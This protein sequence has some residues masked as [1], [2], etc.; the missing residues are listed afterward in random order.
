[1]SASARVERFVASGE[2]AGRRLDVFLARQLPALSRSRLQALIRAGA[3]TAAGR[4]G[5][6]ST[7]VVE[8]EIVE[9]AIPAP[10]PSHLEPEALPLT[11]VYEDADLAVIDK[12][13]G[14]V[15]HPGAGHR[16]GTLVHALLH[17]LE[18]L[19]GIGGTERPGIVHRLDRG[20]SGLIVIAKHDA[21]HRD[22]ARQFAERT[23]G[24][25]YVALVWGAPEAGEVMTQPIGRDPR[26]RKKMS[27]RASRARAAMTRVVDVQALGA[28]SLV[29]VAIGTGRTHQIRVHMSEAG[30]AIVGDE[31]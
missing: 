29:R 4:P 28:V 21:A 13:A 5:K 23:V 15:V 7:P 14:M 27:S 9:I 16:V 25:E 18:G 6:A 8:G 12:P 1:V 10:A 17:H 2:D 30:H 26:A 31:L 11:I 24:K 22:L 19:S 3:V 20:T